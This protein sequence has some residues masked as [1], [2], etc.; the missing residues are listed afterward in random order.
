MGLDL[1][2]H[3]AQLTHEIVVDLQPARGVEDHDVAAGAIGFL[4]RRPRH[5]DRIG[6]LGEHRHVDA[7]PED[8]Q[9]L[10]RRRTLEIGGDQQRLAS[11]G[12]E[13]TCELAGGG[14]LPRPLQAGEHHDRRR[15][16]AHRELARLPAE[17]RDELLVHDLDDLLGGAQALR[18]LRA[19]SAFLD[20]VDERLDD[21]DVDVG[22]EQRDADLAGD[23]VDV[24]LAQ[25]AAA[26]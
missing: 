11:F 8:A 18:D 26:A 17:R 1:G 21:R 13:M 3:A 9:L 15:L 22:F 7:L 6:R 10:D 2:A 20:P 4:Q 19:A 23:L 24:L 16:R 5:F 25:A 12:D 14:G